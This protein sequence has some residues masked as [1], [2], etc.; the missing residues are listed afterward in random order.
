MLSQ[1]FEQWATIVPAQQPHIQYVRTA[2]GARIAYYAMG[3]GPPLVVASEMQW[4][5]LGNTLGL[6]EYYRSRSDRGLGR[7]LTL[8]RYDARGTGLS[9]RNHVDFSWSAR[10]ADLEAVLGAL[11]IGR[12]ALFG[13]MHGCLTAIQFAA[14]FP[15]RVSH[16]VLVQPYVRGRE[17]RT[18]SELAGV[19]VLE[20]MTPAQW[21][22]YTLVVAQLVVGFSDHNLATRIARLYRDSMTPEA[23]KAFQA[24]RETVDLGDL[25]DSVAVPTLVVQRMFE[26]APALELEVAARIPDAR[27]VSFPASSPIREQWRDE[28]TKAIEGFLTVQPEAPQ[29][30]NRLT[31]RECEILSL[32]SK[33][34]SNREIAGLLVLSERTVA[35]HIANIYEKIGVH[36]RSGATAFALHHR[37]A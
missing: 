21:E 3:E 33:G 15:E 6:R 32:L 16:L 25:L 29:L 28:E 11:R 1:A 17:H 20:R 23:F 10:L 22:Q 5:H 12:F 31:P 30:P 19:G 24:W 27:L 13:H 2:D 8:V 35:R 4:A 36:S 9:D 34:R 26:D 7:G 18:L 14:E 37:L